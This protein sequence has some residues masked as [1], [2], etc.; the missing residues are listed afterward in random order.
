MDWQI[1]LYRPYLYGRC[2]EL[3]QTAHE[4]IVESSEKDLAG[5]G[6]DENQRLRFVGVDTAHR[7][8]LIFSLT[9]N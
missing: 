6:L 8:I 4:N 3:I 9:N 2:H 1:V 7:S 5:L